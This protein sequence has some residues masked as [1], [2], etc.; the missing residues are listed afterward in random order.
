MSQSKTK[1]MLHTTRNSIPAQTRAAV[2]E[3]LNAGLAT[4]ID[5]KLQ[6]KQAHW[7]LRGPGFISVHL[8]LDEV[9]GGIDDLA[10]EVAERI[11]QLGGQAQGTLA[12]IK[13]NTSLDPY[14]AD[15]SDVEGHVARLSDSLG[16]AGAQF[17]ELS[18]WTD[19]QGDTGSSDLAT[20][21]V[22]AL[23]VYLWKLESNLPN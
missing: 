4:L 11:A 6:T 16:K 1:T 20:E 18:D 2:V 22:R 3:R 17:R 12:L 8:L 5:L 23:D 21:T 10:D 7:T 13:D 19:E 9:A 15:L 14:P